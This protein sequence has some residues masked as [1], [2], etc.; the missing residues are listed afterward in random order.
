MAQVF[1][2]DEMLRMVLR[3]NEKRGKKVSLITISVLMNKKLNDDYFKKHLPGSKKYLSEFET[4]PVKVSGA[5]HGIAFI[6]EGKDDRL[7]GLRFSEMYRYGMKLPRVV[8]I[9]NN[10]SEEE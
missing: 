4:V 1:E 6:I 8:L 2:I 10:V 5:M 9:D 7:A 3:S